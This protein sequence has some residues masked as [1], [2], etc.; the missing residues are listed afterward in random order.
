[1]LKIPGLQNLPFVSDDGTVSPAFA[2]A[3]QPLG[4]GPVYGKE[5]IVDPS[6]NPKVM[7]FEQQYAAAFPNEPSNVWSQ[8]RMTLQIS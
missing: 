5:A 8:Q 3:I 2:T 1:M 4:G 7:S 6:N